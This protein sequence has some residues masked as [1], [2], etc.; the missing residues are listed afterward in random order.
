MPT[1][2]APVSNKVRD[3]IEEVVMTIEVSKPAN[4]LAF[5]D[6]Q[7]KHI[8]GI[9]EGYENAVAKFSAD[10]AKYADSLKAKK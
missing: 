10:A 4:P 5:V 3:R 2:P 6:T 9:V 7:I 8:V 1:P